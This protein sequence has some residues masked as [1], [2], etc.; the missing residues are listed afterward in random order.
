M[1]ASPHR[2]NAKSPGKARPVVAVRKQ[3]KKAP[4]AGD[5]DDSTGAGAGPSQ[6]NAKSQ[7]GTAAGT[8]GEIE[9]EEAAGGPRLSRRAAET[10]MTTLQESQEAIQQ[11]VASDREGQGCLWWDGIRQKGA[12]V[13]VMTDV[14]TSW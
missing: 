9:G 3:P 1:R 6:P 5:G 12:R 10:V 13:E 11:A 7:D 4:A 14:G 8:N 2:A